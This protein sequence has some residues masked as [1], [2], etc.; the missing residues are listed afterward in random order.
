M[1]S[2]V[3]G[4]VVG[5]ISVGVVR[6][7]TTATNAENMIPSIADDKNSSDLEGN[8]ELNGTPKFLL[9]AALLSDKWPNFQNDIN[10]LD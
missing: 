6:Q 9:L 8:F 1:T 5:C 3:S 10:G 2:V 7:S 4:E